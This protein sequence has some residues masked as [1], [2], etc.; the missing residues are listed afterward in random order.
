MHTEATGANNLLFK[1][2]DTNGDYIV[3]SAIPA[4][5]DA[6]ADDVGCRGEDS[7]TKK[8]ASASVVFTLRAPAA[9]G[10]FPLAASYWYGTEK[11]SP[12]GCTTNA[13]GRQEV[14]GGFT[15]GSGRLLFSDVLQI[16]VK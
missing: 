8:W 7:A 11:A 16:Q 4:S 13:M 2:H 15:G 14:R 6:K 12:L 3:E 5:N 9:T 10:D 1:K